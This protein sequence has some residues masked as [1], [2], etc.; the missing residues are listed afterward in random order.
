M[1][2]VTDA[3]SGLTAV[4]VVTDM[5]RSARAC[6]IKQTFFCSGSSCKNSTL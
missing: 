3:V 2:G 6:V 1:A 5:A 4:S